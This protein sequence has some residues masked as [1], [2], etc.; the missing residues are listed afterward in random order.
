MNWCSLT[1][2]QFFH[3]V[4]N[5]FRVPR[6]VAYTGLPCSTCKL[7]ISCK[8]KEGVIHLHPSFGW[9]PCCCGLGKLIRGRVRYEFLKKVFSQKVSSDMLVEQLVCN[10][11][12]INWV[13]CFPCKSIELGLLSKDMEFSF[14]DNCVEEI[15]PFDRDGPSYM[16]CSFWIRWGPGC[17]P[18]LELANVIW[19]CQ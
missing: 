5:A 8:L 15:R 11:Q 12:G 9:K 14:S 16:R 13:Y 7:K 19:H 1:T 10:C 2:K 4:S 3:I 18:V 6:K 17:L